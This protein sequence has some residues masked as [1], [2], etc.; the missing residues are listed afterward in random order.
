[1]KTGRN[2]Q[3]VGC[4][5]DDESEWTKSRLF[6]QLGFCG[7]EKMSYLRTVDEAE[8]GSAGEQLLKE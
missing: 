7:V 6:F 4:F 1:M 2:G 3:K 5:R 8:R